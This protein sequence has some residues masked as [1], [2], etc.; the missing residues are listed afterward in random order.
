M[1]A[2][3][4]PGLIAAALLTVNNLRD[5]EGDGQAE[6]RTLVVRFGPRFAKMEY[7]LCLL[8]AVL[9]PGW[10]VC[11]GDAPDAVL[12]A[13]FVAVGFGI[14]PFRSVVRWRPGDRL[15]GALA[16]TGRLLVVYA[17]AFSLGRIMI[18]S[19]ETRRPS[20]PIPRPL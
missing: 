12:A 17:L 2:G 3:I 11:R 15:D 16:G 6:K 20:R 14:A 13:S 10:L 7:G 18:E 19:P 5:V 8:G 1:I 4:A 9:V